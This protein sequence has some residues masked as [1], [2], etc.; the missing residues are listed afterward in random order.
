MNQINDVDKVDKDNVKFKKIIK[1]KKR[2]INKKLKVMDSRS[3]RKL[4]NNFL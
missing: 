1:N 2:R 4:K 3:I